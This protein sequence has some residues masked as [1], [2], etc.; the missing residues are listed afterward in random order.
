M[1][2]CRSSICI[3]TIGDFGG[4]LR[5]GGSGLLQHEGHVATHRLPIQGQGRLKRAKSIHTGIRRFLKNRRWH[6]AL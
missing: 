4:R 5:H 2:H 1:I 6:I 3:Q